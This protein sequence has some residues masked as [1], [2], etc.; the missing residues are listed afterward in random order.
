MLH[1][2]ADSLGT[3]DNLW[4]GFKETAQWTLYWK[5]HSFF[6]EDPEGSKAENQHRD[7]L[8]VEILKLLDGQVS[9]EEVEAH[10]ENLCTV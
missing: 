9:S 6:R 8:K 1:T 10:F 5:S 3:A 2:L 7:E 4:N